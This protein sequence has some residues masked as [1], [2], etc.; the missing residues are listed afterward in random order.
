MTT[1]PAAP[2]VLA[3]TAET[4]KANTPGVPRVVPPEV[5]LDRVRPHMAAMGIT[6]LANVTGLDRVGVPVVMAC[7]PNAR[8]LSV[9]Q[10]KG[11]TLAAAKASG[12]MEAIELYHAEHITTPLLYSTFA[13]LRARHPM[14]DPAALPRLSVSRFDAHLRT[15]WIQGVDLTSGRPTLVPYE[16]VHTAYTLPM[17]SGSG[18]FVMST[19]GLASGNHLFEA[20]S[21][22]ICEVVERDANT[23]WN[24]ACR[25]PAVR[26]ATRLDLDSVDAPLCREVLDRFA[27]AQLEVAVWEITSDVEIPAYTCLIA[28]R[29]PDPLRPLPPAAGTG[30][31]PRRDIA[32]A[33]ALTEAAQSRLTHISGSR[34]DMTLTVYRDS[35][36]QDGQR[37]LLGSLRAEAPGRRFEQAPSFASDSVAEDL[38]WELERLARS[39]LTQVV[40]V[41]LSKP[42]FEIPVARVIIPGLETM[43]DIPGYVPGRRARAQLAR[44]PS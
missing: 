36:D 23:L 8:S 4:K 11:L 28:E 1:A 3:A 38:S 17:P 31:S 5:T 40:V 26:P 42:E 7:R 25:D 19:N 37:R 12:V 34:D 18:S 41:D 20:I 16:M 15:L 32:L 27:A 14:V 35:H 29:E 30:C 33:R 43:Y 2:P 21:H 13:E 39:G 6:R 9:S 22:G 44:L 24:I 10:G